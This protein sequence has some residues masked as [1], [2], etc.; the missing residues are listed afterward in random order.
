MIP[1]PVF[2]RRLLAG[3]GV[4][5]LILGDLAPV[6]DL[7]VDGEG[8]GDLAGSRHLTPRLGDQQGGTLPVVLPQGHADTTQTC[9]NAHTQLDGILDVTGSP[10]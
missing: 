10:Y 8:E 3:V 9:T 6:L 2:G 1:F 5:Y 4:E 7:G